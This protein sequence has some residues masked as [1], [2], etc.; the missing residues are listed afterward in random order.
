MFASYVTDIERLLD[1]H[2]WDEALREA[3]DL[4]RLA[5]ALSDPRLRCSADEVIGWCQEWIRPP[6]AEHDAQGLHCERLV[7]HIAER[8]AEFL[9]AEAVPM[10]ALRRLQLRRHVRMPPRG[11]VSERD[12]DLAQREAKT[13]QTCG[14]LLEAAARW[15]ARSA[16]HDPVVQSNLA[17]LAVLR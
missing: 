16:V 15:Y 13:V 7:R 1:N 12:T 2:R 10:R 11:F 3:L 9:G 14:A 8:S 6:G 17:R 5:V 4:P